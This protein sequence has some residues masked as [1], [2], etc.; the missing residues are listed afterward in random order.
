MG[1]ILF[2]GKDLTRLRGLTDD[3]P[4]IEPLRKPDLDG[5]AAL[6]EALSD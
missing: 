6:V 1:I 2:I 4:D 5:L 3:Y